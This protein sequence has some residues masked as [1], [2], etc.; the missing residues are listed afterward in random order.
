MT[1]R[2]QRRR[3]DLAPVVAMKWL[4]RLRK[5]YWGGG[6]INLLLVA[7]AIMVGLMLLLELRD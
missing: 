6:Q 3:L 2:R 7:I 5:K 4:R 1:N